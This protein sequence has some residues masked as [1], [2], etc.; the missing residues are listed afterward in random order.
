MVLLR[1]AITSNPFFMLAFFLLIA[2]GA[3]LA[4]KLIKITKSGNK[5]FRNAGEQIKENRIA[6]KVYIVLLI[7]II[8]GV[9]VFI[10]WLGKIKYD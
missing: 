4:Y 7:L 3:S 6:S 9:I 2:G 10:K 8:I 1:E 5:K